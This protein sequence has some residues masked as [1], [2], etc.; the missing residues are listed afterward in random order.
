MIPLDRRHHQ[1]ESVPTFPPHCA[2]NN[3]CTNKPHMFMRQYVYHSRHI[4]YHTTTLA[5]HAYFA[6]LTYWLGQHTED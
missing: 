1:Q 6:F 5:F 3:G 2:G 4:S